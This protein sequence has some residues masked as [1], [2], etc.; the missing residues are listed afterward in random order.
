MQTHSLKHHPANVPGRVKGLKVRWGRVRDGRV[1]LR[2]RLDGC[3][4]V[5]IP[6]LT[7]PA[8]ADGLWQTT[9]FELF[10]ATGGSTY[11][12]FNFSPSGAWA[13]YRFDGYRSEQ[14]DYTPFAEPVVTMD[15]GRS[16][17]AVTVFL[18]ARELAGC[19][20]ASLTAVV[21]ERNAG[22]SYWA[23]FHA[24]SKPD[25]HNPACFVLPVP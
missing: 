8:R 16:V 15:K 21:E 19:A 24:G 13:A 17:L 3:E 5:A 6:P 20:F 4:E 1:M 14:A 11:R 22:L 7:T 12:E 9:C 25:F 18:D 10:L 23:A 2:F